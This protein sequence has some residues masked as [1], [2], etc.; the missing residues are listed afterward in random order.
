VTFGRVELEGDHV[1]PQLTAAQQQALATTTWKG[2]HKAKDAHDASFTDS[3]DVKHIRRLSTSLQK[4]LKVKAV[5]PSKYVVSR[6]ML[7]Q[8]GVDFSK[9]SV[10]ITGLRRSSPK[11][12]SAARARQPSK[13]PTKAKP[14]TARAGRVQARK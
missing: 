4:Y 2:P 11:S 7:A 12:P 1:A 5:K 13:A 6:E 14:T 10:M 9:G 3:S 8:K